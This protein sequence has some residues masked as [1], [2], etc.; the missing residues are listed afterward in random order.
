MHDSQGRVWHCHPNQLYVVE[1]T[2]PPHGHENI[3][4]SRTLSLLGVLPS[5][6]CLNPCRVSEATEE[7][8][9]F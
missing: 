2:L 9:I 8:G 6:L 5:V 3:L 4:E 1:V 7:A